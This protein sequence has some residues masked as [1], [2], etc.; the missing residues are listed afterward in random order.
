M[1][2]TYRGPAKD[3]KKQLKR[4]KQTVNRIREDKYEYDLHEGHG[5]Y[6]ECPECDIETW[7]EFDERGLDKRDP[8]LLR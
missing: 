3:K 2:K 5:P 8:N 1:G 4:E 7:K 6:C